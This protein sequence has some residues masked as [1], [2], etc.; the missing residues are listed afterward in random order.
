MPHPTDS[1]TYM[2]A[3]L[4]TYYGRIASHWKHEGGHLTLDVTI[5][6]NT[7]ATVYIPAADKAEITEGNQPLSAHSEIKLIGR[8]N[9]YAIVE[10]GSG[11]YHF[12]TD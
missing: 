9:G 8:E 6:I 3:D 7:T 1:L 2:N 4:D 10:I 12:Q 5:P 11:S